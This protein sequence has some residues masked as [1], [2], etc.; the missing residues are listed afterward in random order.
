MIVLNDQRRWYGIHTKPRQEDRAD[1]NLRA[2]NVE[3]FTPKLKE[4][5]VNKYTERLKYVVKPL[6]RSYIFA[7]FSASDSLH[8]V[9]FTRGV[10]S[11]ISFGGQPCSVDDAII[12]LIQEREGDEGFVELGEKLHPGDKVIIQGGPFKD[13][14][15]VLDQNCTDGERVSVLLATV[16]YQNHVVINRALAMKIT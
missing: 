12:K 10:H 3:T 14:V 9:C 11:V 5:S 13:L 6:F 15:G 4:R 16:T 7:R 1:S 2:W 8:K